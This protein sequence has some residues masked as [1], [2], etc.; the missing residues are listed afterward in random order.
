[1][2]EQAELPGDHYWTGQP[3]AYPFTIFASAA[4]SAVVALVSGARGPCLDLSIPARY[5]V[6]EG[7]ID[8]QG[9]AKLLGRTLGAS[10]SYLQ[11]YLALPQMAL[12]LGQRVHKPRPG[13]IERLRSARLAGPR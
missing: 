7:F 10:T 6:A 3:A 9:V 8:A 11:R 1:M 2:V 12:D 5:L 4:E 13:R